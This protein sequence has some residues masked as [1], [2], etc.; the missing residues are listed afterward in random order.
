MKEV[1]SLDKGEREKYRFA[2]GLDSGGVKG[3]VIQE[4]ENEGGELR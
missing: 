3:P 2:V 4:Q 1:K